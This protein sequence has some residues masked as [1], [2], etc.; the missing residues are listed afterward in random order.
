MALPKYGGGKKK[1]IPVLGASDVSD[2]WANAGLAP[3]PSTDG[4]AQHAMTDAERARTVVGNNRLAVLS[5]TVA[6]GAAAV[7]FVVP[8]AVDDDGMPILA[9]RPGI[10]SR[11]QLR[12]GTTAS[13]A[14][15]ETP[16]T[17]TAAGVVGGISLLGDVDILG[18]ADLEA[19]HTV[20]MRT[21]PVDAGMVKRGAG[22]LYRFNVASFLIG[23]D[24]GEMSAFDVDEYLSASPDPLAAVAPALVAHLGSDAGGSLVLL[25]RA[26]GGQPKA[27]AAT[28]VG[29]DQYGMDVLATT[30]QGRESVRL[31][32]SQPVAAAED[33]RR[34][35]TVMARGARF[36]LGMA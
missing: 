36:K 29:I 26:F 6:N 25:C 10:E 17:A 2:P 34:E 22:R 9:I 3:T 27:T 21:Q 7:G 13:L 23:V 15:A 30:P 32:F 18:G 11:G 5:V 35:L 33:V 28:L 1:T 16:L 24:G 20:Y 4:P 31:N 19:A 12:S 14:I 8:Y